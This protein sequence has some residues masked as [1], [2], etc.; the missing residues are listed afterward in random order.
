VHGLTPKKKARARKA[1]DEEN[2]PVILCFVILS[3]AKD[4][5]DLLAAS[6]LPTAS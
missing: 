6:M 2:S 3:E 5:C 1:R 4:L